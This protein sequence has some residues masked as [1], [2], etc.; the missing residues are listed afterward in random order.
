MLETKIPFRGYPEFL[1]KAAESIGHPE[2]ARP[3]S[4]LVALGDVANLCAQASLVDPNL[5]EGIL[6]KAS[7]FRDQLHVAFLASEMMIEGFGSP[8]SDPPARN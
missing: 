1:E 4:R 8:K 3:A 6:A 7:A 5:V 2:A